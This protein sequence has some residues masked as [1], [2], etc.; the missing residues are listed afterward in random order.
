MD[1]IVIKPNLHAIK[2][3]GIDRISDYSR[4]L[5]WLRLGWQDMQR[6]PL[7]SLGYGA[8]FALLGFALTHSGW[9]NAQLPLTLTSGFL[10]VA[11]FLAVVFYDLSRQAEHHH[12]PRLLHIIKPLRANGASIG[13]YALLLGFVLSIW[14]RLSAILL[15]AAVSD[16]LVSFQGFSQALLSDS[17]QLNV[18]LPYLAVGVLLAALVFSLSV[19]SLPMMLHRKVDLATALMTSLWVVRT[20]PVLML[21]WAI[22]IAGLSALG[23]ATSFIGM[24]VVFPLIGHAT[25]HVYRDLVE[26]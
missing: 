2:L 15:A 25:W 19:V 9:G 5:L 1:K 18:L 24:V 22:I 12:A 3:P 26:R 4:P 23:F 10:M 17:G 21:E 13:L 11:P 14:E 16:E 20:N 7:L 8:L 6:T